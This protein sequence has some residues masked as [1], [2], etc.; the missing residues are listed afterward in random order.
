LI[1]VELTQ[2]GAKVTGVSSAEDALK[3]IEQRKFDLLVS[4]IGMPKMDGYELMRRVRKY[5]EGRDKRIPAVAL[6]AYARVQDRMQAIL[7]G[8]ST[9]VAKPIEVSELITVVAGLAGRLGDTP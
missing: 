7:A 5:E 2:H 1:T 8:F 3:A 9:H 6:T 4:D